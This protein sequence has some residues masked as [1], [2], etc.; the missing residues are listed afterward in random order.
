MNV[1]KEMK[2]MYFDD[3]LIC[4]LFG[5]RAGARS[6]SMTQYGLYGIEHSTTPFRAFFLREV[7]S[8]IYSSMW[9]DFKDRISEYEEMHQ[10]TVNTEY[11]DN[12]NG[13]NHAINRATGNTIT[14]KGFRVSSG[15]HT[16][17]LKSLAAATHI[18]IDEA[19]EVSK[20]DFLK[21]RL[22]LRKKGVDLKI[23]RAFNPPHK[24]HWIWGDYELEKVTNEE[25]LQMLVRTSS[26]PTWELEQMANRNTKT[27]FKAKP[28]AFKHIA[29][30]TNHINNWE[31]LNPDAV[32]FYD[33]TL[34]DDFHYY[35]VNILGL[36]P[37]EA[38]DI[39]YYEYDRFSSHTDRTIKTG[40]VLHVGMDFNVTNMSAVVHVVD[41]DVAHAVEEAVKIFDTHQMCS[42]L[43]ERFPGH[44]I[45]I[46]PDASGR[47]RHSNS[48]KSD[49][50][51]IREHGFEILVD[52]QNPPVRDRINIVNNQ[53]RKKKYLVNR[54]NCPSYSEALRKLK[55][56]GGEPDKSSGY[57]HQ[58]DAG[59]YFVHN[60]FNKP[61]PMKATFSVGRLRK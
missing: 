14:T 46:Y 41:D 55:Y 22:S 58:T 30:N 32:I 12:K 33:E 51:T 59:G 16:A 57:D 42:V 1:L 3:Y 28:K 2:P 27:Y 60:Q 45:I 10:T 8:T 43:K 21:L 15:T 53:F 56:K 61:K 17:N 35:V 5:G 18:F 19:D 36:I 39:V 23:I 7:H 26:I 44:R 49:F 38:G 9:Q 13:E 31:N 24:D 54:Y 52:T 50:D 25:L 29:I 34:R 48:G 20:E 6:Y 11:S 4:D 47:N 40:D 37:N